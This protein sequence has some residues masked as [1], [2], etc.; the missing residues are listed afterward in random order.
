MTNR[1]GN[2]VRLTDLYARRTAVAERF[3]DAKGTRYGLGRGQARVTTAARPDRLILILA[4]AIIRL[5]GL[6]PVARRPY[7]AGAWCRSNDP[8]G[9]RGVTVGRRMWGRIAV[10][11]EQLP[12]EVVRATLA[13]VP[14]WG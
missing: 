13:S 4:P 3:R 8:T 9:C 11:P 1:A 14:K 2:A 12:D 10:P 5:A 6:G 7:R